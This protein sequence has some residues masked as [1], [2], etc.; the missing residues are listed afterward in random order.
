VTTADG[1]G[2]P[3]VKIGFTLVSGTGLTPGEVETDAGG[4]WRQGGFSREGVYQIRLRRLPGDTFNTA[5]NDILRFPAGVINVSIK[6]FQI[7][8][9]KVVA[10]GKV[11]T[12]TRGTGLGNV[13]I[14][15]SVESGAGQVPAAIT[16]NALGEW[17]QQF[18]I[19]AQYKAT[20]SKGGFQFTP[21]LITLSLLGAGGAQ[22]GGLIRNLDFSVPDVLDVGGVITASD[23]RDDG[24]EVTLEIRAVGGQSELICHKTRI[25]LP[26]SKQL[27][28][29]KTYQIEPRKSHSFDGKIYVFTPTS[30]RIDGPKRGVNFSGRGDPNI[31]QQTRFGQSCP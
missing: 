26:W 3:G 7:T 17:S 27:E 9:P 29:G 16:T 13:T 11:R 4:R 2:I 15:F 25:G 1:R 23:S 20:A 18:E 14:T 30:T 22:P 5:K 28:T 21:A 31:I 10:S 6:D 8:I 12:R 19:G 24:A